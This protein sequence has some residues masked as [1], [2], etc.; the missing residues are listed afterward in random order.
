[1]NYTVVL[2]NSL[3]AYIFLNSG[4]FFTRHN[5]LSDGNTV[6]QSCIYTKLEKQG[7]GSAVKW[8]STSQISICGPFTHVMNRL[9]LHFF[10][11]DSSY[12]NLHRCTKFPDNSWLDPLLYTCFKNSSSH[13]SE[14]TVSNYLWLQGV[15]L[16]SKQI[17][18]QICTKCIFVYSLW[19]QMSIL[20]GKLN[21]LQPIA[22]TI[23][24]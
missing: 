22:Q 8:T 4:F 17:S 20:F 1:M 7:T 11:G 9:I 21:I 12:I 18:G 2:S 3:F 16:G 13:I 19:V 14:S 23:R 5:Q 6:F 15:V 10:K 24:S